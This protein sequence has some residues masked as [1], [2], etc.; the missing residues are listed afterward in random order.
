MLAGGRP[1]CEEISLGCIVSFVEGRLGPQMLVASRL[2]ASPT[3]TAQAPHVIV[4]TIAPRRPFGSKK[5]GHF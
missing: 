2:A 4:V 5:T 1:C 3:I